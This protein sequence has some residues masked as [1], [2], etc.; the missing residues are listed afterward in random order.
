MESQL[1]SGIA[2]FI[3]SFTAA[4]GFLFDVPVPILMWAF[5]GTCFAISAK[6]TMTYK[7]ALKYIVG[8][9]IAATVLVS[10]T[11]F[12]TQVGICTL[13]DCAATAKLIIPQRPIAAILGFGLVYFNKE[14]LAAARNRISKLGGSKNDTSTT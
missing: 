9:T 14:I 8:G 1:D 4:V 5:I 3:G 12:A 7:Q 11:V 6:D 13:G 10:L 2:G